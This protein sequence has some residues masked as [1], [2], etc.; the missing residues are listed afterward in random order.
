M[1]TNAA[2][3]IVGPRIATDPADVGLGPAAVAIGMFDGVHRGHR[4]LIAE[5]GH[6]ADRSGL[7]CG[8][9]TFADHPAVLLAP[10]QAPAQLS[11]PD[12]RVAL[13]AG[14]GVDFVLVL[15]LTEDLLSTSAEDFVEDVLVH[16]LAVRTTVVGRNFRFGRGATGDPATL[17]RLGRTHG[18]A[19]VALDLVDDGGLP[20]SST[21][22]RAEIAAGRVHVAASLL[23]RPYSLAVTVTSVRR[24]AAQGAVLEGVAGRRA[25]VPEPGVYRGALVTPDGHRTP[26]SV[27]VGADGS[28]RL[29]TDGH[30][31]VGEH[32]RVDL[33]EQARPPAPPDPARA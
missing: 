15:P 21:R 23:G 22:I 14:C 29:S 3:A 18:M 33:L 1:T 32:L 4:R 19:S 27:A 12:E 20:I 17:A 24:H 7:A 25:A 13:L 10:E 11:T 26:T 31:P 8:V 9:V 16:D 28:V 2:P 5:C 30:V 6:R